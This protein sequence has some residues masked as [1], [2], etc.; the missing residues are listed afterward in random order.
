MRTLMRLLSM[1]VLAAALVLPAIPAAAQPEPVTLIGVL[2]FSGIDKAKGLDLPKAIV[3][4][5][6]ETFE[7]QSQGSLVS[8]KETE[9]KLKEAGLK[10][11]S[12]V[13]DLCSPDDIT[14]IGERLG[15]VRVG[16]IELHGYQEI[17]RTDEKHSYHLSIGLRVIDCRDGGI[18]KYQSEGW[19]T[20]PRKAV[21]QAAQDL[22][23]I[24]TGQPA[25]ANL[26]VRRADDQPVIVHTASGYYHLLDCRHLPGSAQAKSFETKRM[27]QA[28]GYDPCPICFPGYPSGLGDDP[29][30]ED[31]IGSLVCRSIEGAYRQDYNPDVI[32]R[33]EQVAQPMV[34]DCSRHH[35]TFRFRYLDSNEIGAFSAANGFIYLTRGLIMAVESDDEL[36]FVLAHEIAHVERQHML[37]LY[38]GSERS[39]LLK[40]PLG[41]EVPLKNYSR[42]QEAEA[43]ATAIGHLKRVGR[44][45]QVYR[46][47]LGKLMDL[48]QYKTVE[49]RAA[50]GT[51]PA[52]EDR[53][54]AL[55]KLAERYE[56]FA[57][58]L[59]AGKS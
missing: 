28:E 51:H 15:S 43:D 38:K 49:A 16:F 36:A 33:I 20:D 2:N 4:A 31:A 37:S 40:R 22:F 56:A 24:Y 3:D 32:Y 17:S 12:G 59:R 52:P 30:V 34:A 26:G 23:S 57:R 8:L 7:K 5:V 13:M 58:A 47:F 18:K 29:A 35:I 48:K 9:K 25:Q 10:D 53:M 1:T 44:N 11:F 21:S 41:T 45:W 6:V 19:A 55:D 39:A 50:F 46:T 42:A 14:A 54:K 27:A